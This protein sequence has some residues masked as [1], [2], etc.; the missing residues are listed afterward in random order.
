MAARTNTS[1]SPKFTR[2]GT[3]L[4]IMSA[5]RCVIFWHTARM[6]ATFLLILHLF[7]TFFSELIPHLSSPIFIHSSPYPFCI[8][9]YVKRDGWAVQ[10]TTKWRTEYLNTKWLNTNEAAVCKNISIRTNKARVTDLDRYLDIA[11]VVWNKV[12]YV[13]NIFTICGRF[14]IETSRG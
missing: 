2:C 1:H 8:F 7:F 14:S 11:Y 6:H 3:N 5:E 4:L 13:N 9:M 10:K 12:K